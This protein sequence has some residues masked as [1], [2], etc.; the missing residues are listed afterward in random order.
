LQPRGDLDG[1]MQVR[2]ADPSLYASLLKFLRREG[3]IAYYDQEK[4]GV[5]AILPHSFGPDEAKAICA[6]VE[7]W[8]VDWP[9]LEV[10]TSD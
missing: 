3:C 1:G 10:E 8:R 9:D 5:E 7:R 4:A 6:L 2:L